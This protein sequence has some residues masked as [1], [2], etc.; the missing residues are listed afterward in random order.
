MTA[1]CKKP[2]TRETFRSAA[3]GSLKTVP[4]EHCSFALWGLIRF[5][6]GGSLETAPWEYSSLALWG[7]V[8]F[9]FLKARLG[10][11]GSWVLWVLWFALRARFIWL[12][13]AVSFCLWEA[14]SL[15][16]LPEEAVRLWCVT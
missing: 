5:A 9:A 12:M 11:L 4:W 2:G 7:L 3:F 14:I 13:K 6:L 16:I 8:G 15:D 10:S 1:H